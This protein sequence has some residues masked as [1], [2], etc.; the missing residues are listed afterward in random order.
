MPPLDERPASP[1]AVSVQGALASLTSGRPEDIPALVDRLIAQALQRGASDVHLVS[2]R[3]GVRVRF[4]IDGE[5][6]TVATLP[7]GLRDLVHQ[8]LKVMARLVVY[9]RREPQDGRV[10]VEIEGG[11]LSLRAS[12]L[13]SLHGEHAV[14]RLP[15]PMRGHLGLDQLGLASGVRA[16]LERLLA[17]PQGGVL[18]TGPA[19]SGKTTT[20]YAALRHILASR[21]GETTVLTIED[22]IEA[23]IEGTT[24]TQIDPGAGVDFP[25]A[26][27]AALRAD[28]NVLAVGEIRDLE[29]ATTAIQAALSGHLLIATVH[30]GTTAGVF[31]RLALLGVERYLLGFAIAGVLNQRLVRKVC[32]DCAAETVLPEELARRLNV[33]TRTAALPTVCAG[34]GCEGCHGTGVRGRLGVFELLEVN[35]AVRRAVLV[36]GVDTALASIARQE[37]QPSLADDALAKLLAGQIPPR[38]ALRTL[39]S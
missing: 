28:P 19:S 25:R 10:D 27:R 23:E 1:L 24:Q 11:R 16:R 38:E 20:I 35:E 33:D 21:G 30:A 8:R 29:T 37:R 15:E 14:L 9:Q 3:D 7:L 39:A 13:P 22:P 31:T 12:F 32:P 17:A 18:L 36:G 5:L 34:R 2:T 6:L 26:L 4:R